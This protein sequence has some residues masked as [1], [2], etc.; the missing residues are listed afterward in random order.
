MSILE[1]KAPKVDNTTGKVVKVEKTKYSD[2]YTYTVYIS[3][4]NK[5][6]RLRGTYLELV[7][8][9]TSSS[10]KSKLDTRR[11]KED[12]IVE[13][14]KLSRRGP[15]AKE[16]K[17]ARKDLDTTRVESTWP[18]SGKFEVALERRNS[19]LYS[20]W[21]QAKRNLSTGSPARKYLNAARKSHISNLDTASGLKLE[22]AK[23]I[24]DIPSEKDR[25]F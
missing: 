10:R 8:G 2:S 7:T 17:L 14:N 23:F 25:F 22:D 3:S 4:L 15:L 16:L 20:I 24:L 11:A 5:Q 12:L 19:A 21:S 6:Y 1:S 18:P 9:P 13:V